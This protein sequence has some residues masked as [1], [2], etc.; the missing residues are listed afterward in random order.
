MIPEDIAVGDLRIRFLVSGEDSDGSSAIF[1]VH[2]P[3]GARVPVPHFHDAYEETMYGLA[4]TLVWTVEGTDHAVGVGET[5]CIRRGEVHGFVNR[6]AEPARQ[7]CVVSPAV[8]GPQFFRDM[9]VAL[10]GDGPPDPAAVGTVMRRHG[11]TPAV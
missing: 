7:L 2:V 4:G 3:P 9:G 5:V 11:L 10:A 1:E 8:I 6:G